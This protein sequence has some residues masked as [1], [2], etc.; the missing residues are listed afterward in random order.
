[1]GLLLVPVAAFIALVTEFA[2]VLRRAGKIVART[3]R[4][5]A[6]RTSLRD[7]TQ[8][9]DASSTGHWSGSTPCAASR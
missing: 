8:R 4:L 3:R 9:I 1:M 6:F 2:V 5:D 7:L